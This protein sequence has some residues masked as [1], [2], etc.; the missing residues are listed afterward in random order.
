MSARADAAARTS[1][2][3]LAAATGIFWEDPRADVN[4]EAVA[5]RAN[6]S[7]RTVLRRFGSKE[8]LL[9]A[10]G[11]REMR[12]VGEQRG[13]ARPGDID[14]TVQTLLDHYEVYGPRVLKLL[15]AEASSPALRERADIGREVHRQWCQKVFE[16]LI[17][18]TPAPARARRIAQLVAIC[19][20]QTWRLLRLDSALSR[21]QTHEALVEMISALNKES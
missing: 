18:S 14:H 15:S 9:A 16:P 8:G 3:I 2:A 12:L 11:D 17:T 20:V 1:E 6:V 13:Q 4:L 21:Q 7:V 19:D 10:A 5:E